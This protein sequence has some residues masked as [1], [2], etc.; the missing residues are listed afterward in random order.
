[1]LTVVVLGTRIARARNHRLRSC[2]TL[3]LQDWPSDAHDPSTCSSHTGR[4]AD[5]DC[6]VK[7]TSCLQLQTCK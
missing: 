3:G 2:L 5:R 1:M 7:R 6:L 4:L